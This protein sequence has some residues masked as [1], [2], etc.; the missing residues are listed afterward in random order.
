MVSAT[1]VVPAEQAAEA[2]VGRSID[3]SRD[4]WATATWQAVPRPVREAAKWAAVLLLDEASWA[5]GLAQDAAVEAGARLLDGRPAGD[6][7]GWMLWPFRLALP[8]VFGRRDVFAHFRGTIHEDFAYSR[9]VRQYLRELGRTHPGRYAVREGHAGTAA[10]YY[11]ELAGTTFALCPGGWS[12][13]SPRVFEA[14]AAGAVP[15]VVA[16]GTRLPF[17]TQLDWRAG[18]VKLAAGAAV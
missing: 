11:G 7:G 4:G 12:A 1:R 2:L 15:V 17:E 5:A 14:V 18:A 13:W 8:G 3:G 10:A 6:D 16:D 9:G